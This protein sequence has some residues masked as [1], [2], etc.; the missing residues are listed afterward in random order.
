MTPPQEFTQNSMLPGRSCWRTVMDGLEAVRC[1]PQRTPSPKWCD[2]TSR[3][4]ENFK[5]STFR[6][7]LDWRKNPS[8]L[9]TR[10]FKNGGV[11][12]QNSQGHVRWFWGD[13]QGMDTQITSFAWKAIIAVTVTFAYCIMVAFLWPALDCLEDLGKKTTQ[14]VVWNYW[15]SPETSSLIPS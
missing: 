12:D 3:L 15:S 7:F 11:S 10:W 2:N 6:V 8:S 1:L 14:L 4:G 13:Q 9:S 5:G